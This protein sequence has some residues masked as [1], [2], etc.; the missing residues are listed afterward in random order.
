MF[1]TEKHNNRLTLASSQLT[2]YSHAGCVCVHGGVNVKTLATVH[3]EL[4]ATLTGRATR[5]VQAAVSTL[6]A[7]IR[8]VT[9]VLTK[10]RAAAKLKR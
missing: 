7:N 3:S 6:K 1:H 10:V 2:D 5:E 8:V 9:N 4:S